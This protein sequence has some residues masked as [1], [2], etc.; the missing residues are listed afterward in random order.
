MSG[1]KVSIVVPVYKVEK[2]IERCVN[3]LIKQSMH[4]IEIILVN[5]GS[6][7][8]C[9][10]MCEEYAE[11][12]S[13]VKVIHKKNGGLSDARNAGLVEA[14]GQ[15]VLFVDSDDYISR[16]ACEVLY[17]NVIECN[18]DIVVADAIKVENNKVSKIN[19][20]EVSLN[21]VMDGADFLKEQ[22]SSDSMYMAAWLNLYRKDFLI[23]SGLFFKKAILHEDEQWTPRVFLKAEKVKYVKLPFY[24]YIIRENSIT[25][26]KDRSKN[27]IDLINTCYELEKVYEIIDDIELKKQLNNYLFMLFLNAI[28]IGDLYDKKYNKIYSKKFLIGK[29]LTRKNKAKAILFLFN[30]KIYKNINKAQKCYLSRLKMKGLLN[31]IV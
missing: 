5:D 1:L 22:L 7:D 17:S 3:S 19:H 4:D 31:Y 20:A 15:Y 29:S 9:P 10:Q 18:L 27:G 30:K 14:K 28:H 24:Y 25:K 16:N 8:K 21:R 11:K 13:R 6:P 23:E 12:D 2:E 26:K